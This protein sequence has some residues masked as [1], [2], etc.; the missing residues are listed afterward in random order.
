M[1]PYSRSLTL[2]CFS[3]QSNELSIIKIISSNAAAL[4]KL[5]PLGTKGKIATRFHANS[6]VGF[7]FLAEKECMA[8][9]DDDEDDGG[10][11]KKIEES[12]K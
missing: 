7:T 5:I 3:P 10:G 4:K 11:G 9:D 2:T 1:F 8:P 12:R 6:S